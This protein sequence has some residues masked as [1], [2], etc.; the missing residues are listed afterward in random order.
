MAYSPRLKQQMIQ[1][2]CGPQP[3]MAKH[4]AQQTGISKTTLSRWRQQATTLD[5]MSLKESQTVPAKELTWKQ[6][7]SIVLQADELDPK[8]LGEFLRSKGLHMAQLQQL[9]EAAKKTFQPQAQTEYTRAQSRRIKDLERELRRK[10]KALS[11]AAALL[12]LKK[13]L[14]GIWEDEDESIPGP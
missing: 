7:L 1:K 9:R 4:L 11:E 5:L 6:K 13:K 3:M 2:M 12:V 10:D 14:E 8:D